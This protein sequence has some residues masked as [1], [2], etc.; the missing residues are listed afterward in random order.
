M[1]Y[2][3]PISVALCL[4]MLLTSLALASDSLAPERAIVQ[5]DSPAQLQQALDEIGGQI[6]GSLEKSKTY[7]V[8]VPKSASS[9]EPALSLKGRS[10]IQLIH[11]EAVYNL[12]EVNQISIGFPD[13]EDPQLNAGISP[14]NYYGQPGV[15]STGIDSAQT[16]FDGSGITVAIIDN[17]IDFSHPL[18]AGANIVDGYDFV[19][20]D[21]IPAEEVGPLQSHGTFVSGLIRLTAPGASLMPLRVFNENGEGYEWDVIQAIYWAIDHGANAINM[22]FCTYYPGR[23]LETAINDALNAGLVLLASVGNDS[24][25]VAAYPAA[26]TGVIA[27]SAIDT[28]E[29]RASF[30]SWG[31]H[32]DLCAP[33]VSI[34][35]SFSGEH[36][37]GTWSGTS[38]AVALVTGSV[39]LALQA[40]PELAG[41]AMQGHI[42]STAR[43]A[44]AWGNIGVPNVFYGYGCIDALAAV[45][46]SAVAGDLD[47]SGTRDMTDLTLLL[48]VVNATSSA[49]KAASD[50][51]A[52]KINLAAADVNR[53][54]VVNQADV[55]ATVR[56]M[57]WH[58]GSSYKMARVQ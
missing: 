14:A 36:P 29:Y 2:L 22:S 10:G 44:L 18:F 11:P 55:D 27:V 58:A 21:S 31:T 42:R 53:D 32:V 43:T 16:M 38:F 47:G 7:L 30:S 33:G 5:A 46:P 49:S 41:A 39:A 52:T 48:R 24:T 9:D 13:E 6:I 12:P 28:L 19:D 40:H 17:G 51:G 20:D 54:G 1:K 57:F 34:Y 23:T 8:T 26:Y 45:L 56:Y 37:W 50:L 15:Y 4:A 35:S 3:K 25:S